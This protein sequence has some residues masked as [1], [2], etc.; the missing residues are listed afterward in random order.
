MDNK[1]FSVCRLTCPWPPPCYLHSKSVKGYSSAL[2]LSVKGKLHTYKVDS[3]AFSKLLST[4]KSQSK[5]KSII[6]NLNENNIKIQKYLICDELV[7]EEQI[8]LFSL[9]SC[10]FPVKTNFRHLYPRDVI[11]RACRDPQSEESEMHFCQSCEV[12]KSE[13]NNECLAFE[14]IFGSL[15][16]QIKFIKTFKIIAR[17]WNLILEMEKSTI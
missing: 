1:F 8:L 13:R 11:C 15:D 3:Y 5:C 4:A 7:K 16:V 2:D 9:R 12:F 6:L 17:K 10:S 14:N